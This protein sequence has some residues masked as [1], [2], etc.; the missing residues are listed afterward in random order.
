MF[1]IM[2]SQ[3]PCRFFRTRDGCRR[4]DICPFKHG[5]GDPRPE[6]FECEERSDGTEL[7]RHS[8]EHEMCR[9]CHASMME[10]MAAEQAQIR[11][12][13]KATVCGECGEQKQK[14]GEKQRQLYCKK[15]QRL[16]KCEGCPD[17]AIC[18]SKGVR[19]RGKPCKCFA[20]C[21]GCHEAR[22]KYEYRR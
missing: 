18:R 17:M 10:E 11:R 19:R 15:C 3:T 16:H 22:L 20:L 12:K 6:C 21:K 8:P 13:K 9:T 2:R 14:I 5:P 7:N 1:V 4:G